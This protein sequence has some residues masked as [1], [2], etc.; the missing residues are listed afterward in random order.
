MSGTIVVCGYGPGISDAVARRFGREGF[1]VALVGR[2]EER[3]AEGC[4]AL[5]RQGVRAKPFKCDVGDLDAVRTLLAR[6]RTSLGNVTVVHWNALASGAGDLLTAP[7][8]ELHGAFD[9]AV[10][11][12]VTCVQEAL[13]DLERSRGA[14][15]VTGGGL[16][17]YG[18]GVDRLAANWNAMGLS[19]AKAAQHKLVGL[20]H[21][22]LAPKGV[23]V[24]EVM[25]LGL[26][27]GSKFDTGNAT[28][29]A[30]T[31]ADRFFQI[32]TER[33]EPYVE[34]S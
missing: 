23:Y 16:A 28:I 1:A 13:P 3:L 24:G 17:K 26:V 12:L 4:A 29:A 10:H 21:Q 9:V 15:L 19:V 6:V 31:V 20:L 33:K 8:A 22:K 27:K 14:V 30:D 25:V 7:A 18:E 11:G 32:Y 34:L 5:E 2:T